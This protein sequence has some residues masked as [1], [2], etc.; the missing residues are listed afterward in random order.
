MLWNIIY[1][2]HSR[3]STYV[4][5]QSAGKFVTIFGWITSKNNRG[6]FGDKNKLE[7]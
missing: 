6:L 2:Y 3:M 1:S 5:C 4:A 7:R